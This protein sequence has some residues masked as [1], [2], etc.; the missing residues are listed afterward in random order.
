MAN[1]IWVVAEIL[2][3]SLIFSVLTAWLINKSRTPAKPVVDE[4]D[5]QFTPP[6]VP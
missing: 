4:I 5:C 6:Q 1:A 2:R 3:Q